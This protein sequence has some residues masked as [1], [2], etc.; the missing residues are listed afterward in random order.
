MYG[1][2]NVQKE[3]VVVIRFEDKNSKKTGT[4]GIDP[5]VSFEYDDNVGGN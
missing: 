4:D 1:N 3:P 5:N 2:A